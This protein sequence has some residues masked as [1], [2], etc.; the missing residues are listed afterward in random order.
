M[1]KPIAAGLSPADAGLILKGREALSDLIL[2]SGVFAAS[3]RMA[4]SPRV[5]SILRDAL[6]APQDEVRILPHPERERPRSADRSRTP[7]S[8]RQRYQRHWKARYA[9]LGGFPVKY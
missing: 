2:R 6:R 1:Q 5:A 3:R 9:T 4:T 7:R 8:S